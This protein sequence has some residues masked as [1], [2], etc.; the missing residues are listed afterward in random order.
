MEW[1]YIIVIV[2]AGLVVV[3]PAAFVWYICIGGI[4]EAITSKKRAKLF[5]KTPTN[6][7]CTIN[8]DCPEGYVCVNGRC[9]PAR[10]AA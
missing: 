4:C 2:I 7:T 10:S 6:L 1:Q 5:E 8:T 3:F 9:M